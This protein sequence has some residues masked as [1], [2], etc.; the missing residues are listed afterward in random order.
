MYHCPSVPVSQSSGGD[1]EMHKRGTRSTQGEAR[2]NAQG[3]QR[4]TQGEGQRNTKRGSEKHTRL[5][6]RRNTQFQGRTHRGSY[7]SDAHMSTDTTIIRTNQW[8]Q[9]GDGRIKYQFKQVY[10]HSRDLLLVNYTNRDYSYHSRFHHQF[11][12]S[13]HNNS[14]K[15]KLL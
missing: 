7:G 14:N 11:P 8:N 4:N 6:G 15:I 9:K 12:I 1:G 13:K 2:R 5:G 3:G 10:F